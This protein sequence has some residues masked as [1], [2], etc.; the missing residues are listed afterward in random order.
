MLTYTCISENNS[1]IHIAYT[2]LAVPPPPLRP[3]CATST[4]VSEHA[5]KLF[6]YVSYFGCH[7]ICIFSVL[8]S[9]AEEERRTKC[10]KQKQT[11]AAN[12]R[13]S[14]AMPPNV[15]S[16]CS[17]IHISGICCL[18]SAAVSIFNVPHLFTF[19]VFAMC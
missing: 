18:P 4:I 10:G 16:N 8:E 5:N 17:H 19:D 1:C 11:Q 2:G 9:K 15:A 14:V 13:R 3:H 7:Q 12:R 6:V